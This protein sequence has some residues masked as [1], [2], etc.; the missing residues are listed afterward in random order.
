MSRIETFVYKSGK[1]IYC[2]P[3][4]E[5]T[6]ADVDWEDDIVTGVSTASV[7]DNHS[8]YLFEGLTEQAY[9]IYEYDIETQDD[10]LVGYLNEDIVSKL[11]H[12]IEYLESQLN[13]I[14]E[15]TPRPLKSEESQGFTQT[16]TTERL[17]F[18]I[19]NNNRGTQ[20]SGAYLPSITK[21]RK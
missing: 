6:L 18:V 15:N 20:I 16:R 19:P 2:K 17:N 14:L 3:L 4:A 13:Q 5:K 7:D 12:R 21:N 9:L 1:N 10:R 11:I 8:R